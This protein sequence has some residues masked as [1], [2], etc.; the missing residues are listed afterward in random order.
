[1]PTNFAEMALEGYLLC[2]CCFE[3]GG[4]DRRESMRGQEKCGMNSKL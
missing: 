3:W 2:G 4:G 1:M